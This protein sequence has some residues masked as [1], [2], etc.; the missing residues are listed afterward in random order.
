MRLA[1]L[2]ALLPSLAGAACPPGWVDDALMADALAHR[3]FRLQAWGLDRLGNMQELYTLE[4]GEWVVIATTPTH[5]A[6]VISQPSEFMGRL[7]T[8]SNDADPGGFGPMTRG[9]R[10]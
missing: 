4:S 2:L 10:G 3:G 5:C 1:L 8:P 7:S 6:T 9:E